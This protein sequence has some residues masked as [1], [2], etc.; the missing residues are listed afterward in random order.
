MLDRAEPV[1]LRVLL[2]GSMFGRFSMIVSG[3]SSSVK[4]PSL[5]SLP[6]ATYSAFMS[7]RMRATSATLAPLS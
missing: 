5:H 4:V 2:K 1:I 6:C 3:T 7:A